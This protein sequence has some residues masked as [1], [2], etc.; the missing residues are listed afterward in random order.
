MA[1]KDELLKNN[2]PRG[3]ADWSEKQGV[4]QVAQKGTR[5]WTENTTQNNQN[6]PKGTQRWTENTTQDGKSPKSEE[7]KTKTANKTK[8]DSQQQY[9]RPS[10]KTKGLP[11]DE[12]LLQYAPEV[13]TPSSSIKEKQDISTNTAA[14]SSSQYQYR[15]PFIK[16]KGVPSHE[17]LLQYAPE[18]ESSSNVV[19]KEEGKAVQDGNYDVPEQ[20]F[21]SMNYKKVTK[22]HIVPSANTNTSVNNTTEEKD[23]EVITEE[24]EKD[25]ESAAT[26]IPEEQSGNNT[27]SSKKSVT[28][29]ELY[30][31]LNPKPDPEQL[32]K[33]LKRQRTRNII[34]A[35]GDGISAMANLHYTTK[36]APSMYDGKNTMTAASQARYD[37][38][39]Q[40]YKDNLAAYRQGRMKAE[41]MD[42]E[43]QWRKDQADQAQDNWG[44]QFDANEEAR[45]QAQKNHDDAVAYKKE[46]D[47][48]DDE[49][50]AAAAKQA[51]K[52]ADREYNYKISQGNKSSDPV[53]N[54]MYFKDGNKSIEINPKNWKNNFH[55]LYD[56]LVEEGIV[57]EQRGS[58]PTPEQME[59]AVRRHW[60]KSSSV[61]QYLLDLSDTHN[62]FDRQLGDINIPYSVWGVEADNI[63]NAMMSDSGFGVY[64][65]DDVSLVRQDKINKLKPEEKERIIMKH[66]QDSP[67]A[68]QYLNEITGGNIDEDII[69]YNPDDDII[70]WTPDM[71]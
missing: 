66:W 38:I 29:K 2:P 30:E 12:E 24:K 35:L 20:E 34:A 56:K 57:K 55:Q 45:K 58:T 67:S 71:N 64:K 41:Q 32:K 7:D 8:T 9:Y 16:T 21:N 15:K 44:K 43:M 48:K 37:K 4:Q 6:Y 65:D 42:Q 54:T 61:T 60:K 39:M 23:E 25:E 27:A 26:Q 47:T 62:G 40:D 5:Q 1:T 49:A 33:D 14:S 22:S 50:K 11:T 19:A 68:M 63:F 13:E 70:E 17:E 36:G 18:A 10:I 46:R 51:Q 53:D 52:N 28:Y 69:E 59:A 31:S 3:S